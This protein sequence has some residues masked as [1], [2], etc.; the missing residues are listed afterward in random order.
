MCGTHEAKADRPTGWG[1]L[2]RR[3]GEALLD[4]FLPRSCA[5]CQDVWLAAGEGLWCKNCLRELSWIRSPI[6]P[7]CGT[8]YTNSPSAPD[9]L[10]GECTL[11]PVPFDTARSAVEHSGVVR[12]RIHQLKFGGRL[13]WVPPLADLLAYTFQQACPGSVDLVLPVPLHVRRLRQRGFNQSALMA[14]ALGRR[15]RLPV[16]FDILVRTRWTDPQTRLSREE[17]R[18]NVKGSFC[19]T[20]PGGVESK[21]VLLIDDVYTTGTTLMEC[22][23]ILKK[24][25]AGEVHALTVTRAV[26]K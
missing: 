17:R 23:K 21:S 16:H 2:V 15:L 12:D 1:S 24:A 19:V 3:F 20:V 4:L 10:C 14:R 8:P 22:S 7:R 11:S 5:G 6:C 18:Q 25:G 13:H 26:K 9:H